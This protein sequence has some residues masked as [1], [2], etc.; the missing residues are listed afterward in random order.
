MGANIGPATHFGKRQLPHCNGNKATAQQINA[1]E[2]MRR[3]SRISVA[4]ATD[5]L[6]LPRAGFTLGLRSQRASM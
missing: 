5:F 2:R 3:I 6:G 1:D 4:T